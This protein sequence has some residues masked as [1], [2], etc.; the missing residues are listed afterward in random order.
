MNSRSKS[1]L[2]KTKRYVQ[3][4]A[5]GAPSSNKKLSRKF[6]YSF[7]ETWVPGLSIPRL[8]D[9]VHDLVRVESGHYIS[10]EA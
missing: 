3:G 6:G 5:A 9:R 10:R 8:D 2:S 7:L 4:P 1:T